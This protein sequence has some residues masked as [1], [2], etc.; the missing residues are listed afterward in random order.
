MN[1]ADREAFAAIVGEESVA[2]D[3]AD[4]HVYESDGSTLRR[5]LAEAIVLV[6]SAEEVAAVVS[7]CA[8]RSIPFLARGAGTG[9]SGGALALR[10]GIIVAMNRMNRILEIDLAN[11]RAVVEPGVTNSAITRAVAPAGFYYAPDPSSQAVCTIGGNVAHNSGG[12]HTLK[13]GV[14][15]N[16]ILAV[17]LVLPDGRIVAIEEPHPG[18]RDLLGL[19]VGSEGTFGI[20]TKVAVRLTRKPEAVRTA[21]AAFRTPAEASRAVAGI[22]AAGIVPAALDMLDAVVVAALEAAFGFHFP[23]GA[24]ALLLVESDGPEAGIDEEAGAI[25]AVCRREGAIEVR[26]AADDAERAEVWKARKKAFGALGRLA[27]NYYTQDGVIPR[28]RLPETLE[29]IAEIGARHQLRIANVFHA[30]DGNLHPCILFD[31]R[32]RGERERVLAAGEEIL[33]VCIALGGSLSGEH[34][35]GMEK[36]ERMSLMF[37]PA[38]IDLMRRIKGVFDPAGIANPEKIFPMGASCG[39]IGAGGGA[40]RSTGPI[41]IAR[42]QAAL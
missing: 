25:A 10:G 37:T 28:T 18:G 29:R 26:L 8:A 34:G 39:E 33:G 12:P 19:V 11:R 1:R 5:A 16:H 35:I 22:I 32:V 4:L 31:D 41:D 42:R 20:V 14:T 21:L 30:G 2:T 23:E 15:A 38:D 9:L 6:N 17:E 24:G 13:Y 27:P 36:R 7:L 40:G 3:P